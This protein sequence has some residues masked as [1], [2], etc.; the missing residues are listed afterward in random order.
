MICNYFSVCPM[1]DPYEDI[2]QTSDLYSYAD[3][4]YLISYLNNGHKYNKIII[5]PYS[6]LFY[7]RRRLFS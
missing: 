2:F 6:N 5:H 1:S 7:L 3:Y 4:L